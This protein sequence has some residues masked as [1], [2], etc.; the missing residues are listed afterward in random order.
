M[1]SGFSFFSDQHYQDYLNILSQANTYEELNS[2]YNDKL[3]TLINTEDV[4]SK[5]FKNKKSALKKAKHEAYLCKIMPLQWCAE[6]LKQFRLCLVNK[7]E[8]FEAFKSVNNLQKNVTQIELIN[9]LSA[10]HYNQQINGAF[11]VIQTR[12]TTIKVAINFRS[13]PTE[14]CEFYDKKIMED[15]DSTNKFMELKKRCFT[16]IEKC[17][18]EEL[19]LFYD[20][21]QANIA[22]YLYYLIT[23]NFADSIDLLMKA[24]ITREDLE[25]LR[26]RFKS[27]STTLSNKDELIK[28]INAKIETLPPSENHQQEIVVTHRSRKLGRK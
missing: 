5:E 2:I 17:A 8:L 14:V 9:S 10:L 4:E 16:M 26:D 23:N 6:Y 20:K 7:S 3:E 19:Q 12:P 27:P 18:D 11:T 13:M 22:N 25:T 1:L 21:Y 24:T 28:K 15:T